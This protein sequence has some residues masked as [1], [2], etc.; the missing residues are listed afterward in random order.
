MPTS[1]LV[2]VTVKH[3]DLTPW[4]DAPVTFTRSPD[5]YTTT[6]TF[7]GDTTTAWSNTSGIATARLW[8]NAEGLQPSTYTYSIPDGRFGTFVLPV[9]ETTITLEEILAAQTVGP[10]TQLDITTFLDI[11]RDELANTTNTLL[12]D[13]ML[14][15]RQAGAGAVGRTV[16]DK[17]S[18]SLSVSDY[19]AIGDGDAHPLSERY[20]TLSEA[21]AV[22]PFAE[23]LTNSID[24]CAIQA[25]ITAAMAS[26]TTR[27]V[28]LPGMNYV[29]NTTFG[30]GRTATSLIVLEAT[31]LTLRSTAGAR[32]TLRD[33]CA[34]RPFLVRGS[35]DIVVDGLTVIDE[36]TTP[37]VGGIEQPRVGNGMGFENCNRLKVLNNWIENCGTYGYSLSEDTS[38]ALIQA[39][40]ISFDA[41]TQQIRDSALG[42]VGFAVNDRIYTGNTVYNNGFASIDAF[43]PGGAWLQIKQVEAGDLV[44]V[45]EA[46][47]L[48]GDVLIDNTISFSGSTMSTID[49][50]FLFLSEGD[51]FIPSGSTSGDND[52]T[53][54]VA[55]VDEGGKS[56]TITGVFT[57]HGTG[58]LITITRVGKALVQV[59]LATACDDVTFAGNTAK[60]CGLYGFELFP[61]VLSKNLR[62][63]DNTA[64][65]CG[66]TNTAGC[67]IK[68]GTNQIN[69]Y[70][71]G[72]TI[73]GCQFGMNLGNFRSTVVMGN[74]ITNCQKYG[75]AITMSTHPKAP[76]TEYGSL[77]VRQNY[78]GFTNDPETG[79]L[80]VPD[81]ANRAAINI[82][83]LIAD[84]GLLEICNNTIYKWGA[85]ISGFGTGGIKFDK[86]HVGYTNV[87]IHDNTLVD[88]GGFLVQPLEDYTGTITSGSS[89]L[90]SIVRIG[91]APGTTQTAGWLED[92]EVSGAAGVSGTI[93]DVNIVANTMTMSGTASAYS[94]SA[95]TA[96]GTPTLTLTADVASRGVPAV[97]SSITGAG[98]PGGTTVTVTRVYFAGTTIS[99]NNVVSGIVSTTGIPIGSTIAGTGIPSGTTVTD[100]SATTLTLSANATATTAVGTKVA[101]VSN[102]TTITMSANASANATV[103]VTAQS[104]IIALRSGIPLEMEVSDN[105]FVS[106]APS[107]TNIVRVYSNG[108]K[109]VRN[110]VKGFGQYPIQVMGSK[111]W[112]RG[113][114]VEEPNLLPSAPGSPIYLGI[115]TDN[116]GIYYLYDNEL[117]VTST[118]QITS[119]MTSTYAGTVYADRNRSN[120]EAVL[121]TN[122][123]GVAPSPLAIFEGN[124][125]V[126]VDIAAPTS[127]AWSA[128]DEVRNG[129]PTATKPIHLWRCIASGSPGTWVCVAGVGKGTSTQRAALT[130]T[131]SENGMEFEE[132]DTNKLVIYRSSSSGWRL[133]ATL[134]TAA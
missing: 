107:S 72:N 66:L 128:G 119:M 118:S 70:L 126:R 34:V 106:T 42:L 7:P 94:F 41:A 49:G 123:G 5:A 10:W 91:S 1:R 78:I 101:L 58:P 22:Y 105:T 92:A 104:A 117:I 24:V 11:L 26:E 111:V 110:K 30:S 27:V 86:S 80:F 127:G 100:V 89:T 74:H 93:T 67:G 112:V 77:V 114:V 45:D 108:G 6:A 63:F 12:G 40:T 55:A 36:R 115:A 122:S 51:T 8:C 35:E 3:S 120:L 18:E 32:L 103:T 116:T 85:G 76:L 54:T 39:S 130:M 48:S 90:A 73:T 46:A 14:G 121:F 25:A 81:A 61:K 60:D 98:I 83:G 37:I 23:A 4:K 129:L 57:D 69:A 9:G 68:G 133:V 71:V 124:R 132:S 20:A 65:G 16:H 131:A 19:G 134:T 75:L 29:V 15:F 2:T 33:G 79:D 113:N 17:L 53:Y 64:D 95:T 56:L 84:I 125:R 43:D 31:G 96:S 21:Q 88:S 52:H 97:G 47:G 82:N 28:D 102:A 62:V 50:S 87:K 109:V 44:I 13:G 59:W 99:G 38:K